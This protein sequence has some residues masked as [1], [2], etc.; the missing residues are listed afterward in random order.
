[1]PKEDVIS[2]TTTKTCSGAIFQSAV[3]KRRPDSNFLHFLS[4][5]RKRAARLF[6]LS[7]QMR[8]EIF[9]QNL[10]FSV[11]NE[12]FACLEFV[13]C[14][15]FGEILRPNRIT[16]VASPRLDELSEFKLSA[17]RV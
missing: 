11:A 15:L 8:R 1:M 4:E 14:A 10:N 16:Q 13:L 5:F 3:K 9:L 6:R 17:N 2:M 7:S 12:D